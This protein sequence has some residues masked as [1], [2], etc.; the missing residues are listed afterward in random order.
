MRRICA[1]LNEAVFAS[2]NIKLH[3]ETKA[4]ASNNVSNIIIGFVCRNLNLVVVW[5]LYACG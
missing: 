4:R 3:I 2:Q 1:S 5:N